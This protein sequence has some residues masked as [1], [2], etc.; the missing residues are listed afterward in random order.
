MSKAGLDLVVNLV[1]K[2]V[3]VR[4]MGSALGFLW[5]L[6]SPLL[7]TLTYL[8]V[9]KFIFH[10]PDQKFVLYLVTGIVH[11]T[12]FSQLVLQGC[13]WL[14]GNSNLIK[15]IK[16]DRLLLPIAGTGTVLI[17]WT[18]SLAVYAIVYAPL[19]G[20]ISWAMLYYPIVFLGYL[21]FALGISLIL[22][23]MYIKFRDIKYLVEVTMPI[24]FWLTPIVWQPN[25]LT[26]DIA[27][28]LKLNP[29]TLDRKS[30]V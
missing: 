8:V 7:T 19:G 28:W 9:F 18:I 24:M 13:D 3:R 21:S 14:Y 23:V 6:G 12:L 10:N 2:D 22:S 5:S 25:N 20:S 4:Y 26:S 1:K 30:V 16:F 27:E 15:K 29:L 11:W 17:F